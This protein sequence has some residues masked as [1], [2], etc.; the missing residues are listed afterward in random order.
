MGALKDQLEQE[1]VPGDEG[2]KVRAHSTWPSQDSGVFPEW[3]GK[4]LGH[5]D[6]VTRSGC[7]GRNRL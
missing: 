1:G 3:E 6:G 2:T 5:F 4:L 7:Y